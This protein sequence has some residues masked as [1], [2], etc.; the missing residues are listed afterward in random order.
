MDTNQSSI[1]QSIKKNKTVLLFKKKRLLLLFMI[2]FSRLYNIIV[3][4]NDH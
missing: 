2:S 3:I 1:K 4:N